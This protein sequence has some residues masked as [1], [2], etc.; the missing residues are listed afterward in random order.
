MPEI[1]FAIDAVRLASR[2]VS[3]VQQEMVTPALT[4]VDRS[5]VTVADYT[6]QAL[7]GGLLARSFPDDALVA[8][9]DAADLR[10]TIHAETLRRVTEFVARFLPLASEELVCQW[11]DRGAAAPVNR[12]WTLDPIDGTKGFLRGDQYAIALALLVDGQ[13][14]IGVLGYPQLKLRAVGN[15]PGVIVVA[16]RHQGCWAAA[17]AGDTYHRLRVSTRENPADA[18][19]LRSFE[20]G[21]TNVSQVDRLAEVL[22]SE[23]EPIRMDSQAKYALLAAGE[24]DLLVRLLSPK[25]P[26]YRE[27]IWDQ[28][29]GSLVVQEAGG[30]VTDLDGKELDFT[31][32]RTLAHN[33]G[34]LASNGVLHSAALRALRAIHA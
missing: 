2:L 25:Q 20:A 4:K 27:K 24:G 33:R 3:Q 16:V 22:G 13:V 23:A 12:F 15:G 28:A 26:N 18:C 6:S 1:D 11:I 29:A 30:R 5:P 34:V 32:G 21:H 8:E 19:I 10:Q 14:Q 9:E 31:A 17:L 7:I